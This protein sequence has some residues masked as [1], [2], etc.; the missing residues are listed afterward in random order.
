MFIAFICSRK[1]KFTE[2]KARFRWNACKGRR[3]YG[4]KKY[5]T[6]EHFIMIII[7]RRAREWTSLH[8][9]FEWEIMIS[10]LCQSVWHGELRSA[11][12]RA[13][14][15]QWKSLKFHPFSQSEYLFSCLLLIFARI[16]SEAERGWRF[17]IFGMMKKK[18][19]H[20]SAVYFFLSSARGPRE[21]FVPMKHRR[22]GIFNFHSHLVSSTSTFWDGEIGEKF[23]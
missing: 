18:S 4:N 2:K 15:R 5:I 13:S 12:S 11:M 20:S 16:S 9:Q 7:F 21:L 1:N 19:K 8:K 23:E 10:S 6:L 14:F 3:R 17:F 22:M